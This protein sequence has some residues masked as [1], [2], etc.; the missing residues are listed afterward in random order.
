[1]KIGILSQKEEKNIDG[2]NRVTT[3]LMNELLKHDKENEYSFVGRTN[4]LDL[5]MP[6][7]DIIP[8]TRKTMKLNYIVK[9]KK[10]D[11]VHSHYKPFD[12]NAK[13]GCAKIIT[14]YDLLV[15]NNKEDNLGP[16]DFFNQEIRN[17]AKNMD[18]IIAISENTKKDI[19]NCFGINP[20]KIKV[21]YLGNYTSPKY[22]D[23]KQFNKIYKMVGDNYIL[24]VSTM[25]KYKNVTGL[26]KA[27]CLFKEKNPGN[28]IKLVLTGKNDL[29]MDVGLEIQD[30]MKKQKDIVFTGYVSDEELSVLY[31]NCLA[32]AFVSFFE[33]FGLPVLEALSFGKTVICSNTTSIP[34]VGG[35]AVEYCNP[36][37]IESIENS[38]EN[39]IFNEIHRKELEKKALVQA[40]KFSYQKTAKETLEL[41]RQFE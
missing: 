25:R 13:A 27:F 24:S 12:F 3:C 1:M 29:S 28:D 14:I 8:D 7:C 2:I 41:Y 23:I 5:D 33:G 40:S 15:L 34:E 26:V 18:A 37:S 19:V 6:Y 39:I 16:Y 21:I 38:M 20:D 30:C 10:Y 22:I 17:C 4:W 31:S 32:T 11:I 9:Y 36:Y 35:D